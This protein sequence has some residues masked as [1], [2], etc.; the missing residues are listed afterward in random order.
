SVAGEEQSPPRPVPEG[1]GEHATEMVEAARAILLVGVDDHLG[2][3]VGGEPVPECLQTLAKVLEVVDFAV[4]CHPDRAVLV[5][6][7]LL[8]GCQV[9]DAEAGLSQTGRL[10]EVIALIVRPTV[11]QP[12]A[13]T[14]QCVPGHPLA[15]QI[16]NPRDAAH[17]LVLSLT[18]GPGRLLLLF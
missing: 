14:L 18:A 15:A 6:E 3:A 5:G 16:H 2:I 9:D 1:E 8:A 17:P 12:G 11:A 10:V 13:E 4:E 7:G